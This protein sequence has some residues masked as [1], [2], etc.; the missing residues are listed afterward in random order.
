MVGFWSQMLSRFLSSV[1]WTIPGTGKHVHIYRNKPSILFENP[2]MLFITH[3]F[4][5]SLE[6]SQVHIARPTQRQWLKG[7]VREN[8]E[9]GKILHKIILLMLQTG[10]ICHSESRQ[11]FCIMSVSTWNDL[12]IRNITRLPDSATYT[13][14]SVSQM[15]R[16]FPKV[17]P[18]CN[19][20]AC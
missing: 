20:K 4:Y 3:E 19:N 16:R 1:D 8:K 9:I 6:I 10:Y 7:K 15:R 14:I 2:H 5:V 12:A 17:F 13:V 18:Y 11:Y